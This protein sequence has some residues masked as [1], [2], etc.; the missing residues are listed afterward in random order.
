VKL[1]E[2]LF[3]LRGR[4]D[5]R[6]F[7][8]AQLLLLVIGCALAAALVWRTRLELTQVEWIVITALT[9]PMIAT[10]VKR[11]HDLDHS[12]WWV[13][14]NLIPLVGGLWVALVTGLRRGSSGANRFGPAARNQGVAPP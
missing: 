2:L 9:W 10:Q 5:R 11:F 13:L 1:A 14:A 12:G 3:S 6:T 7:W 4:I 8:G